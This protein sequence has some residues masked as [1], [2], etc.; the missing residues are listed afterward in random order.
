[1]DPIKDYAI[2]GDCRSAALVSRSGSIDWLCWPRFD[3]PSIFGAL[4][5]DLAG[6]WRIAPR[7]SFRVTRQYAGNSNVLQTRFRTAT[8][9]AVMTDAM[10]A[11]SEDD[12]RRLFL[13]DHQIIRMVA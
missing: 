6:R 4:L 1:M 9:T 3:S 5:D 7:E 8:G 13:P 11:A 10:P 2:I 12:K